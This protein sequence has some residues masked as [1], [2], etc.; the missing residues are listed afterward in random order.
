MR[1]VIEEPTVP[2]LVA[3]LGA[4]VEVAVVGAIKE[5]EPVENVL[6]CV[7]VDDIEKDSYA[8]AVSHVNEFFE[9]VGGPVARAGG[10]EAVDLVSKS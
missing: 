6:A 1:A 4:F 9:L 10:K 5:V 3:P 2:E 7:G 8:Q